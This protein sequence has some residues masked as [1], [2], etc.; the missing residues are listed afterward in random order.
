MHFSLNLKLFLHIIKYFVA[1]YISAIKF[2]NTILLGTASGAYQVE[3][4]WNDDGKS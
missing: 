2:P 1:L 4:G 3:G